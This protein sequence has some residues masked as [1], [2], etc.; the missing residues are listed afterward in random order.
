MAFAT[1]TSAGITSMPA[2]IRGSRRWLT[3]EQPDE[4]AAVADVVRLREGPRH[5]DAPLGET[6][7]QVQQQEGEAAGVAEGVETPAPDD[8]TEVESDGGSGHGPTDCGLWIR[9]CGVSQH[10]SRHR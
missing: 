4:Q 7:S 10:E 5:V 8:A 9:E 3:G 6:P 2:T 1:M